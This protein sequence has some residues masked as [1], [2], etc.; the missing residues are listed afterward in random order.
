MSTTP[1]P[2]ASAPHRPRVLRTGDPAELL[3]H[4]RLQH[5]AITRDSV[6]LVGFGS[7]RLGL[8]SVRVDLPS[9][10]GSTAPVRAAHLLDALRGAGC[11]GAVG[12]VIAGDGYQAV[13]E[14]R[15]DEALCAAVAVLAAA[16]AREGMR[17]HRLWTLGNGWARPVEPH[18]RAGGAS[19]GGDLSLAVGDPVPLGRCDAT[20]VAADAVLAGERMPAPSDE[21]TAMALRALL[22]AGGGRDRRRSVPRPPIAQTW[23]AVLAALGRVGGA[24]GDPGRFVTA[25]ER[26][27]ELTEDLAAPSRR[28]ALLALAVARGR[29]PGSPEASDVIAA[30]TDPDRRPDPS[31]RAGGAWYDAMALVEAAV[32]PHLGGDDEIRDRRLLAGWANL[33]V[34]LALLAWWNQRFATASGLCERVLEAVPDHALARWAAVLAREPVVVRRPPSSPS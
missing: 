15:E 10:L 2:P 13:T 4:V 19:D 32:R 28:D 34:I 26:V 20:L 22:M 9:L 3:A 23:E 1:R 6:A 27:R 21:G 30:M 17:L 11:S 18:G 14:D 25:C 12:L 8:V 16:T 29:G 31:I 5:G 24:G 33:A 7:D